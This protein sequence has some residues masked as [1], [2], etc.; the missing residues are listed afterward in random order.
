MRYPNLRYGNP[1]ELRHYAQFIPIK[2]LAR[3]LR[4]DQRTV[5]NWLTEREKLPWWVPEILRLQKN[6]HDDM[7]RQ[8]NMQPRQLRLGLV[9]GNVIEFPAL[10]QQRQK[11]VDEVWQT[12]QEN[13]GCQVSGNQR[14]LIG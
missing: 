9:A 6:E 5:R 3:R 8:M 10:G 11:R 2:E 14:Q 4:R 12:P 7:L 1:T 13:G